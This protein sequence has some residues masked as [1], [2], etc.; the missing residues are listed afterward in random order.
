MKIFKP[1]IYKSDHFY[2]NWSMQT[3]E[4]VRENVRTPTVC[5]AGH[6]VTSLFSMSYCTHHRCMSMY[7][8]K[9]KQTFFL[10]LAAN[11]DIFLIGACVGST[12]CSLFTCQRMVTNPRKLKCMDFW[13]S[14]W[15]NHVK[16][17]HN[18]NHSWSCNIVFR[19]TGLDS[20][21]QHFM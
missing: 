9:S 2:Q 18:V 4:R 8:S 14:Q 12:F 11:F 15:L 3:L 19:E 16:F 1:N 6:W 5:V 20:H 17:G 10:H 13:W 7:I 21:S